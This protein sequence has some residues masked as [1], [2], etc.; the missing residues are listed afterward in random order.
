MCSSHFNQIP[1]RR[2]MRTKQT[3]RK[4]GAPSQR[5]PGPV[6]ESTP[7][8]KIP[9]RRPIPAP[10]PPLRAFAEDSPILYEALAIAPDDRLVAL[11]KILCSRRKEV[12]EAVAEELLVTVE[13]AD[14][15]RNEGAKEALQRKR[16]VEDEEGLPPKKRRVTQAALEEVNGNEKFPKRRLR[17]RWALCAQCREKYD[18]TRNGD[19]ECYYHSGK[20]SPD[21]VPISA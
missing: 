4:H 9:S 16:T 18:I 19:Q 5:E 12:A 3:A 21:A 6:I 15:F 11:L 20:P 8:L 13:E 10:R 2:T 1:Q 14:D 7:T 17:P